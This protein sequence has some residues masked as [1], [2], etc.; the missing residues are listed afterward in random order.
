VLILAGLAYL[1]MLA[2]SIK[3]IPVL[4]RTSPWTSAAWGFTLLYV[5][6][7]FLEYGPHWAI[8]GHGEYAFLIAMTITFVV[9]GIRDERQAEPWYWPTHPGQTRAERTPE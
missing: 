3:S 2:I 4:G 6:A 7:V 9:A 1:F 8:P 5:V